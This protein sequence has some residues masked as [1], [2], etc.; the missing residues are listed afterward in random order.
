MGLEYWV[1][2]MNLKLKVIGG[3]ENILEQPIGR[4]PVLKIKPMEG[5]DKIEVVHGHLL[6]PLFLHPSDHSH[7]IGY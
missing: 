6:L 2:Q 4:I 7:E 3:R 5:D 1:E